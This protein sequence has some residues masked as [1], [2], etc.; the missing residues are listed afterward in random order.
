MVAR[1][2]SDKIK[3]AFIQYSKK[4][5][6]RVTIF[7]MLYRLANFVV[8]LIRPEVASALVDLSAGI[9][10]IMIVNMSAYT[11]NSGTEKVA[12][13]FAGRKDQKDEDDY[14]DESNG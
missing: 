12:I 7:W 1:R 10:T 4:M 2:A 11:L 5:C 6:T 9:D 8:A 13:A 3:E 14:D